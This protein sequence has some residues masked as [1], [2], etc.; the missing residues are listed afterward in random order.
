[1]LR[2]V[3]FVE[4]SGD[5]ARGNLVVSFEFFGDA[6]ELGFDGCGDDDW[7]STSGKLMR[8]MKSD[9]DGGTQ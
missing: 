6:L 7:M 9:A 1:L 4:V 2:S 5:H 3:R 8:K